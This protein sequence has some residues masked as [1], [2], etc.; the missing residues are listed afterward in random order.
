MRSFS[1]NLTSPDAAPPVVFQACVHVRKRMHASPPGPTRTLSRKAIC[2]ACSC[3]HATRVGG[4]VEKSHPAVARSLGKAHRFLFSF[5]PVLRTLHLELDD[6]ES[7]VPHAVGGQYRM[8]L[9]E[10]RERLQGAYTRELAFV[11]TRLVV[12][13]PWVKVLLL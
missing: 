3:V 13:T 4:N 7:D 2:N 8:H 12:C 5:S 9:H 11:K 1:D 10:V 6:L